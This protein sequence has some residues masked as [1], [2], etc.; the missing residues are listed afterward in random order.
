M[1]R[2]SQLRLSKVATVPVRMMR[3][4]STPLRPVIS[5]TACSSATW[6]SARAG[7]GTRE[8]QVGVEHVVLAHIGVGED[9][10]AQFLRV[11][12]AGAV[13]DHQPGMRAQHGD[14]VGD[15]LG[16]G[17]ADADID[18]GDAAAAARQRGDRP[19][20]ADRAAAASPVVPPP[21]RALRVMTLPGS[22]NGCVVRVAVRHVLLGQPAE[23]VHV[24]LVVGE[25]H[26]VLEV[27]G[28]GAGVVRRA[29]S[30]E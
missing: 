17:R 11:P 10:V 24:E 7:I 8:R 22:T 18:H 5:A 20:S 6:I 13:A 30:S 9:V 1:S 2:S 14:V 25:D 15:G 28:L 12:Q 29:G 26:E 16:V 23:L 19:A 4:T 3:L 21:S 27:L